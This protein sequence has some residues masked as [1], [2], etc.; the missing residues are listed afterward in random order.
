MVAVGVLHRLMMQGFVLDN[1]AVVRGLSNAYV[2]GRIEELSPGLIVD[3]AH[4]LASVDAFAEWLSKRPKVSSR[5]LLWGMGGG[6][7]PVKMIEAL[8]PFVDEVVTTRCSH[9]KALEPMDM[10][11]TLRE[12]YDVELSASENID[13]ALAEVYKEAD[14]TIVAGSLYLAGAARSLVRQGV[15]EGLEPG[16]GP[17][18]E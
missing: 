10:A 16:Q 7:N 4:N 13:E 17:A 5:I 2:A 9:P 3:G 8:I 6:R 1:D 14:E 12:H 11:V 18:E 15:L